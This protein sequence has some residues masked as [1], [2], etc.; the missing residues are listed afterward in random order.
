[1]SPRPPHISQLVIEKNGKTLLTVHDLTKTVTAPRPMHHGSSTSQRNN[2]WKTSSNLTVHGLDVR[3]KGRGN[4]LG[5]E[6]EE[7]SS[8]DES[9]DRH[10]ITLTLFATTT[11]KRAKPITFIVQYFFSLICTTTALCLFSR[12]KLYNMCSQL[13]YHIQY[14]RSY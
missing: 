1:M 9:Y 6:E 13:R 12:A 2:D 7:P 14:L 8:G 10:I 5:Q 11:K 3:E 4:D